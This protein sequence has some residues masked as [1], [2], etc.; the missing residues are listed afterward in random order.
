[1]DIMGRR[2]MLITSESLRVKDTYL[3]SNLSYNKC[4]YILLAFKTTNA[5]YWHQFGHYNNMWRILKVSLHIDTMCL[6]LN[7]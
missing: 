5:P 3:Q 6:T 1:M 7:M 2:Y 4:P